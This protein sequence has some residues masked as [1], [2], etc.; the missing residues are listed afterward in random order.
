MWNKGTLTL[1]LIFCGCFLAT[2]QIGI[3]NNYQATRHTG[4]DDAGDGD[5]IAFAWRHGLS[6][7]IGIKDRGISFHPSVYYTWSDFRGID[8]PDALRHTVDYTGYGV[9][10]PVQ[11]YVFRLNEDCDC[12]T[13]DDGPG[14]FERNF[15][16]HIT[17]D[18]EYRDITT[19]TFA[20]EDGALTVTRD[21]Q[22]TFGASLGFGLDV[23]LY[24][25]IKFTAAYGFGIQSSHDWVDISTERT[26]RSGTTYHALQ[27]RL[28]YKFN[29]N[30]R[31]RS[32]SRR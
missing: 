21:N 24:S 26:T 14:I 20:R 11:F 2:G 5:Q 30:T 25:G 8:V 7:S 18:L 19:Q 4:L 31:R 32:R 9:A 22:L 6:Y 1:I 10:V 3:V 13:W 12:P 16:V 17:P 27:M 15:F 29:Q 23:P 28:S